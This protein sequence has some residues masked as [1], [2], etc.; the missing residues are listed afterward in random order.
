MDLTPE[1]IGRGN[2]MDALY[3]GLEMP[4]IEMSDDVIADII[5]DVLDAGVNPDLARPH[6]QA[7]LDALNRELIANMQSERD[8][9]DLAIR[10]RDDAL[11]LLAR[12]VPKDLD[13]RCA[14]VIDRHFDELLNNEAL[15]DNP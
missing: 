12:E 8:R 2:K 4:R 7:R 1:Q 3:P 5:R 11:A 15:K 9:G 13:P 14:E 6:I 10:Q